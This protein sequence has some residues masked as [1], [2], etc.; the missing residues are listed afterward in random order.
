M[1]HHLMKLINESFTQ[2]V[3]TDNLKV[4]KMTPIHKDGNK[5]IVDNYRPI[6]NIS[7]FSKII[8]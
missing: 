2:G 3:V 1:V 6:A 5:D 4:S 7:T 8:K